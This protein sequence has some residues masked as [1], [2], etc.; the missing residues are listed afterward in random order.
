MAH[1]RKASANIENVMKGKST[2]ELFSLNT[3]KKGSR[4]LKLYSSLSHSYTLLESDEEFCALHV[5]V[6]TGI[7]QFVKVT[8][9]KWNADVNVR[10]RD[11][12]TALH[13]A[14]YYGHK[15][16][17]LLLVQNGAKVNVQVGEYGTALQTASAKGHD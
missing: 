7:V 12:W 1:G 4:W 14:A 9:D 2:E 13:L 17:A 15:E 5:A 8:L 10:R 6:Y 11:R 3:A 16:V